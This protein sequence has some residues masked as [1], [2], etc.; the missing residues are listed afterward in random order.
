M[1]Y[2]CIFNLMPFSFPLNEFTLGYTEMRDES[3]F[4]KI[5]IKEK[6]H[7]NTTD[8]HALM[9]NNSPFLL[10]HHLSY[11]TITSP[12]AELVQHDGGCRILILIPA[13]NFQNIKLCK[14]K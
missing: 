11:L 4:I 1:P 6:N 9:T 7:F 13:D 12:V 3:S 8:H 10:L 5:K 2:N 14:K